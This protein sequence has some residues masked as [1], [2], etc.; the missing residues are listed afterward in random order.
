MADG[1]AFATLVPGQIAAVVRTAAALVGKADAEDAAQEAIMRAW[2]AWPS[3]QD[4]EALRP[5]LLRITVNI[6]LQW[7]RGRFGK[8]VELTESL[9]EDSAG[10]LATLETDPGTS[11]YTGALDLR[12]ALNQLGY[13]MRVVVVLRYYASMDAS[14][15]GEALGIPAATVRTR[16]RR[17]LMALRELL[18][19]PQVMAESNPQ[20]RLLHG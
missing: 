17:A 13:D 6:C 12:A 16:L 14:E 20:E 11:D 7:R 2:Q 4:V 5:W 9:P 15:V 3:L 1:A 8:R 10:L 19:G 18:G